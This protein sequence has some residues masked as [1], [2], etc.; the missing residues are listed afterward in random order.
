L[1]KA[2]ELARAEWKERD[3]RCR[4]YRDALLDGISPLQPVLHGDQSRVMPHIV[5][6]S[7]PGMEAETLMEAWNEL[8]AISD[9]AACT[10]Q[11]QQ[12][13]HVL[14]AMALP[15]E[16]MAGAVRI[17][18]CHTSVLPDLSAMVAAA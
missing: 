5:N 6:L 11:S 17:S 3:E 9:G 13:S 14:G 1:G 2:A 18:W 7:I 16:R 12:C 10:T 4:A 15:E 8:V